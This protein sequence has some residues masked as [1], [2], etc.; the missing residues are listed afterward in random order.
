[1]WTNKRL[2][3]VNELFHAFWWNERDPLEW[4]KFRVGEV[5]RKSPPE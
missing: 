1:M 2:S 4:L 5:M 3:L